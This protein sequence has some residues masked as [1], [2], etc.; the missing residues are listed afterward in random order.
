MG[1]TVTC[2]PM[3]HGAYGGML[4]HGSWTVRWYTPPWVMGRTLGYF[5]K[6]EILMDYIIIFDGSKNTKKSKEKLYKF[7]LF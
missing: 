1:R 4:S 5:P 7:F 2:H 6:K 3:G